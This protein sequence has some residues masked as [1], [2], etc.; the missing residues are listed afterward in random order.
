MAGPCVQQL[1]S[2]LLLLGVQSAT[3]LLSW[4][5]LG[6]CTTARRSKRVQW[7]GQIAAVRKGQICLWSQIAAFR[8]GI[9]QI[10]SQLSDRV[11]DVFVKTVS[12]C[13]RRGRLKLRRPHRTAR[14]GSRRAGPGT[15]PNAASSPQ[16]ETSPPP[17]PPGLCRP[18]SPC[19][20]NVWFSVTFFNCL[21]DQCAQH[22]MIAR[23]AAPSLATRPAHGRSCVGRTMR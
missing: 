9:S 3:R 20:R 14:P 19:G 21:F 1:P 4:A 5:S 15:A 16:C 22:H 7:S 8:D 6:P 13:R 2:V 23:S 11:R 17:P 12:P 18:R 10:R